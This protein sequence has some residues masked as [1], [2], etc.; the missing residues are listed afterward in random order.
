MVKSGRQA[1]KVVKDISHNSHN[2]KLKR[3]EEIWKKI[4]DAVMLRDSSTIPKRTH[5][6]KHEINDTLSSLKGLYTQHTLAPQR[7]KKSITHQHLHEKTSVLHDSEPIPDLLSFSGHEW[8]PPN[9]TTHYK[10]P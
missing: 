9:N 4:E 2:S 3:Y 1:H 10:G 8:T 5:H 7:N 6:N